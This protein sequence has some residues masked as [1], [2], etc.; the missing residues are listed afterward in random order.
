MEILV[1][2]DLKINKFK[3]KKENDG[4]SVKMLKLNIHSLIKS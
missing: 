4:N 2:T 3:I 1:N